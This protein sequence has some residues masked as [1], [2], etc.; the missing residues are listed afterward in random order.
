MRELI[1]K[2]LLWLWPKIRAV[3][4]RCELQVDLLDLRIFLAGVARPSEQG[5]AAEPASLA[6]ISGAHAHGESR[7]ARVPG[8]HVLLV[9]LLCA[10]TAHAAPS[11]DA[12]N[13]VHNAFRGSSNPFR[14]GEPLDPQGGGSESG[15]AFRF[16]G[17]YNLLVNCIT[18]CSA[19]SGFT[20]NSTFTVGSSTI[21]PIGAL[22]STST[23]SI[24]SGNAG[25]VRMDSNSYLL[26]DCIAGC[27]ASTG[28]SDN[29]G[30]TAGNT[31]I[32]ITGG[33][34]STSPTNCTTGSACAP[35][36]TVDR[37]LFVQAF[38]G[39]SPW[40]VSANGGSFAVTGTFWQSTQ[41]VSCTAANCLFNLTQWDSTALGA[42]SAYGTSPGA[43]NVPGVNAYVTNT[44]AVTGSGNFTVVQGT[45]TNLHIVCDSG[46]SSSAGF[47]DN[48]AFTVGTTAI[49]PIGGLYDTGA[50]PSI[51]NGNAGRARIDSHSYLLVD[52]SQVTQPV[53][54]TFWQSTQPVS[55]A[56]LP[57]L[58]AGSAIVGK[59]GIDQTTPGTTNAVAA[60]NLPATVDTNS[61]NKSAST[62]RTVTAADQPAIAAAGQGATGSAV[63]AGAVYMA[64]N[65]TGNL[66]GQIMCD[67]TVIKNAFSTSGSTQ[68]VAA[69]GS[70]KNTYIC[71]FTVNG[72][73][74]TLNTVK[75]VYGTKSSTDCDTSANDLSV[76]VPI[77]APSSIAPA[78]QN[79]S[80]PSNVVW[81]TGAANNQVC[82][83]L[84]AAQ[85]VNLQ[86]W[87]TSF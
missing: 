17:S 23:P 87:Y 37:K 63:P 39:T 26:V 66:T 12:L 31:A 11:P 48:S 86:V 10:V 7:G 24:S 72:A 1:R 52:G 83:N 33:W 45:G 28:F 84:S 8:G 53:S 6:A 71:G 67:S 55:L 13:A 16:D 34:Y 20:D 46:C 81:K 75:L 14:M 62:L 43:V 57:A 22:Y 70:G 30:F 29:S 76:A 82:V 25:R 38:Q 4:A 51:S 61:G 40:V 32:G 77:E 27:S 3:Y 65:G 2:V 49:N 78:G 9:A 5:A 21:N 85:A 42:P 15:P 80:P 64:G 79:V 74:T 47:A 68:I 18:G 19:S 35:Q 44:P 36:L 73:S 58:V 56:S 69:P 59:V 41:P 54:G 60:T 50:D